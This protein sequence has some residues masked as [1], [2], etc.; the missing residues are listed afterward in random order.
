VSVFEVEDFAARTD[1]L[2]ESHWV[3][4]STGDPEEVGLPENALWRVCEK[5]VISGP[6]IEFCQVPIVVMV[7]DL[8]AVCSDIISRSAILFG[9]RFDLVSG[10]IAILPAGRD[11]CN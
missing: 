6:T 2:Q 7:A 5:G 11:A 9:N 3:D 10:G 1:L 8:E 4:S